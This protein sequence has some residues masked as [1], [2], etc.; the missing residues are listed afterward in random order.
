MGS[1]QSSRVFTE[2]ETTRELEDV[3]GRESP[4][5]PSFKDTFLVS[6]NEEDT[7][8]EDSVMGTDSTLSEFFSDEDEDSE[9]DEEGK[10]LGNET[11]VCD[12]DLSPYKIVLT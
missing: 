9:S 10:K 4:A 5:E 1:K 8:S 3:R 12:G 2:N 7:T 11:E 6:E